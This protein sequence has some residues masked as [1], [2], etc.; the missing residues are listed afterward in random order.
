MRVADIDRLEAALLA[1]S[2][3]RHGQEMRFLCP[4]HD[5]EHPSADWNREKSAWMCRA[6]T[7]KGSSRD[8][9]A[10]LGL[11][12]NAPTE[13]GPRRQLLP[14][15]KFQ[16]KDQYDQVL[17]VHV[18]KAYSDGEKDMFWQR[19]DGTKGLGGLRVESLPRAGATA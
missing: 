10:L 15:R 3:K 8:L 11:E 13:K 19:A 5:D 12:L 14:T 1:R 4:V 7:A 17:G 6:C 2:G 9:A 18:R 16:I